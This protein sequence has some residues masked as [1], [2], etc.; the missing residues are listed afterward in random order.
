MEHPLEHILL[1]EA[2]A[3]HI[4]D[5]V[6]M[7]MC[8]YRHMPGICLQQM[9]VTETFHG[10]SDFYERGA[11]ID[12]LKAM[13]TVPK[14]GQNRR[15]D[16]ERS[17]VAGGE[18]NLLGEVEE[19]GVEMEVVK[20]VALIRG[21]YFCQIPAGP[22]EGQWHPMLFVQWMKYCDP[23]PAIHVPEGEHAALARGAGNLLNLGVECFKADEHEIP[24][25]LNI[26]HVDSMVYYQPGYCTLRAGNPDFFWV[27]TLWDKM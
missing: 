17:R 24:Y 26:S 11:W 13:H 12:A 4:L 27:D 23:I 14:T 21:C 25:M 18:A 15:L 7:R 5:S 10:S 8:I 19:N 9:Q 16:H 22:C 2:Y 1:A 6:C 3:W 20:D